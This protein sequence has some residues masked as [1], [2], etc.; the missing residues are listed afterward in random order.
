MTC[1]APQIEL[2]KIISLSWCIGLILWLT[3]F[4]PLVNTRYIIGFVF[5]TLILTVI[6]ATQHLVTIFHQNHQ[7]WQNYVGGIALLL[8]LS[9]SHIDVDLHQARHW[10]SSKSLH[11]HWLT[12][13]SLAEVQNY[14]NKNVT[15]ETRVLFHYTTQRFHSNFIVYGARS[16]SPR[17]RFVYSKDK[18]EIQK[19]I[20]QIK[21]EYYVI[22]K[23]KIG[24]SGYLLGNKFFLRE[25]FQLLKNFKDFILYKVPKD[26]EI[27]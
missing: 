19:G 20:K 13:S 11:E 7:K 4:D 5:L 9:V 27:Y 23:D 18:N 3:L 26:I 14:L 22:R 2:Q 15:P 17:T 21:P 25:H 16:F 6:F 12:S 24:T 10:I 8:T 1:P